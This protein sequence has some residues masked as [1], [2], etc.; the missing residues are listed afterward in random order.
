MNCDC[1]EDV[2]SKNRYLNIQSLRD[3]SIVVYLIHSRVDK[4]RK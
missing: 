2:Y 3:T 1:T 4:M